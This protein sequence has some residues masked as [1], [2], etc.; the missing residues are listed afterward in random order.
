MQ[1]IVVA[2]RA[3]IKKRRPSLTGKMK[4]TG[5]ARTRKQVRVIAKRAPV[6]RQTAPIAVKTSV[7]LRK[8]SIVR[9]YLLARVMGKQT[10]IN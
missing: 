9:V 8:L 5:G 6:T 7:T 2:Q 3:E 4:I 1:Q 10:K